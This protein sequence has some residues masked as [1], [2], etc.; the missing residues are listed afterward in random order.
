[1]GHI[2]GI[3]NLGVAKNESYME[4]WLRQIGMFMLNFGAIELMSYKFLDTL[5]A[6]EEEFLKNTTKLLSKRII[7]IEQLIEKRNPKNKEQILEQWANVKGLAK[8]RN[9]IAHNPVLPTWKPGSD[10]D[11]SPPDL[12]GVPDMKQINKQNKISDSIS[13][14]GLGKMNDATVKLAEELHVLSKSI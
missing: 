8:W 4:P 9:R 7:R 12:L 11:N 10:P 14:E 2:K 5:E 6:T 3:S 13:L 1:M